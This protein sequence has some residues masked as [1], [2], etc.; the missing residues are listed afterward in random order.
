MPAFIN[1]ISSVVIRQIQEH[2][3]SNVHLFLIY[4]TCIDRKFWPSLG[5][6][7]KT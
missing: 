1:L 5:G 4:A 3:Y 7:T 2:K 6:I